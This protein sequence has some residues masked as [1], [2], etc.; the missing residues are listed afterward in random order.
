M[1]LSKLFKKFHK[2]FRQ[3]NI[4][5]IF[6]FIFIKI[7]LVY[8]VVSISAVQYRDPVIQIY[9][10]FFS[11]YL[12]SWS[13]TSDWIQFPVLFHRISLFIHSKCNSLRLSTPNSQSFPFPP[14]SPGNHK[15]VLHVCESVSVLQIG[16]FV[17]YFILFY[18]ILF[19]FLGPHPWRME[20][21][22]LG[23]NQSYS[24][25]PVTHLERCRI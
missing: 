12:P 24:C 18:F 17:P 4:N 7:Q 2:Q 1:V 11:C 15:S 21:P 9:T 10:F 3:Q 22:K 6:S 16:S 25:W 20:V 23:S 8:S 5:I 13:I 14:L 19:C